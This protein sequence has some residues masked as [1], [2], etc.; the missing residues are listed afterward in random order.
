MSRVIRKLEKRDAER[1]FLCLNDKDNLKYLTIGYKD[2][3]LSD[4]ETF[5]GEERNNNLDFAIVDDADVWHGTI[6]LKHIDL[7]NKKAEY[8]II[9]DRSVHGT[10]LAKKATLALIEYAFDSLHLNKLYLNVVKEN[11][12]AASFYLKCGF[13]Y[14]GLS[15]CSVLLGNK[16]YDLEWYE[17]LNEKVLT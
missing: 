4:C 12:R 9:T 1:M 16:L 2:F 11:N 14:V 8:A 17:L 15:R 3:T 7:I 10:G 6:S 13:K 5:I